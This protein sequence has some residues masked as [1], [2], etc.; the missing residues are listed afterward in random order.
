MAH[1]TKY[2]VYFTLYNEKTQQLDNVYVV[3]FDMAQGKAITDSSLLNI[4]K[5]ALE[6]I[7]HVLQKHYE[8]RYNNTVFV[9]PQ[10]FDF[11][12]Y[13]KKASDD[14][15]VI[16]NIADQSFECSPLFY[17]AQTEN[18]ASMIC[19]N[20][21]YMQ[22][23][24]TLDEALTPSLVVYGQ[25]V[26]QESYQTL[27][28]MGS[29]MSESSLPVLKTIEPYIE[30]HAP[31]KTKNVWKR[32]PSLTRDA[33]KLGLVTGLTAAVLSIVGLV[34][35]V[36]G[37]SPLGL[38]L[39]TGAASMASSTLGAVL[40][41][42]LSTVLTTVSCAT[43]GYFV[44]TTIG[45]IPTGKDQQ[46]NTITLADRYEHTRRY[47]AE[48]P[49]ATKSGLTTGILVGVGTGVVLSMLV[50]FIAT[51]SLWPPLLLTTTLV[52]GG[53]LTGA[54]VSAFL[55]HK[56]AKQSIT[57][58]VSNVA[59]VLQRHQDAAPEL[60]T[61]LQNT[62]AGFRLSSIASSIKNTISSI[63]NIS[64]SSSSNKALAAEKDVSVATFDVSNT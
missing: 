50:P 32:Q 26:N 1:G 53:G 18:D 42:G 21:D 23:F 43:I 3:S 44:G 27:S 49:K 51:F 5:E 7:Q 58:A 55:A 22:Q 29:E 61:Q 57:V 64:S 9:N 31:E 46:A 24:S 48:N 30:G 33:T 20:L 34:L 25:P 37:L 45:K 8:N 40:M 12:T 15:N 54:S 52:V 19:A 62:G 17:V 6:L 36:L 16:V 14:H 10:G 56:F 63:P 41:T 38:G 28:P 39:I 11:Q 59:K 60:G 47:M 4:S 35:V 2:K 13:L